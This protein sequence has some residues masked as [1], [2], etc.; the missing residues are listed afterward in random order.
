ML[1][2]AI[3]KIKGYIIFISVSYNTTHPNADILYT[4]RITFVRVPAL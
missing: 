1:L 3:I 2:K 4:V